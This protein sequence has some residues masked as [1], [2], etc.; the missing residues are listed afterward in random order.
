MVA[1]DGNDAL[2]YIF[3]VSMGDAQQDVEDKLKVQRLNVGFS[4]AQ[5]TIWFVHSKPLDQYRGSIGQALHHYARVLDKAANKAQAEDTDQASPMEAKVLDWFYAT[6]FYQEN[7][8]TIEVF[9]QF[10][11]G[12]YLRQLDAT[13]EH[14]AWRVDFLVLIRTPKKLV[15]IVIEYDGFEHHFRKD[16]QVHVGNHER[17]LHE[18]DLERQLTLE[19]YGYRFLR[20]NRFNLGQDPV[21]TMSARLMRLVDIAI[22]DQPVSASVER[23]QSQASGLADKTLRMCSRCRQI[24]EPTQFFD[25]DLGRGAGGYGRGCRSC[26]GIKG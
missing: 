1:T 8:A 4:R 20:I 13:Y 19:S 14:P 11:I 22:G 16:A 6:S 9:P 18:G 17:Y 23:V 5:E 24:K 26:K 3:P 12:S 10:E 15:Q 25:P 7:M 2:N 21:A